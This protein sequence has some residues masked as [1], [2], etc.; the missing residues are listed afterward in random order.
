MEIAEKLRKIICEEL[1]VDEDEVH[2]NAKFVDDLG[3]D[4][5]NMAKICR[6]VE[7]EF[8]IDI[9]DGEEASLHAVRDLETLVERKMKENGD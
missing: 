9:E 6:F 2:P 1:M 8:S 5:V 4:D 3:A 7:E